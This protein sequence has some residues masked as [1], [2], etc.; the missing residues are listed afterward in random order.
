MKNFSERISKI[1]SN[2]AS[3]LVF[4]VVLVL[5]FA[6]KENIAASTGIEGVEIEMLGAFT[7]FLFI[8]IPIRL[9][10]Q[11]QA[12]ETETEAQVVI[13]AY[14]GDVQ[15]DFKHVLQKTLSART[16]RGRLL[17]VAEATEHFVDVY[18]RLLTV[19]EI[20]VLTNIIADIKDFTRDRDPKIIAKLKPR[21]EQLSKIISQKK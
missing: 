13:D 19:E 18:S 1:L 17:K 21:Y 16:R 5:A 7:V 15:T 6:Y 9:R 14:L 4:L 8:D 12:D 3:Y 11:R 20:R 2:W 10:E